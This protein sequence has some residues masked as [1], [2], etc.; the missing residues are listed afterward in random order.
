MI[1]SDVEFKRKCSF[2]MY[3]NL[4]LLLGEMTF[5]KDFVTDQR[6]D[7]YPV[8]GKTEDCR[9]AVEDGLYR[10]YTGAVR[11]WL[12]QFFPYATYEMTV[13]TGGRVGLCFTIPGARAAVL[14]EG[15]RL[16]FREGEREQAVPAPEC[17]E[18]CRTLA[19]SCRPGAFD[20]YFV[21]RG[22]ARYCCSFAAASFKES[23]RQAAFTNGNVAIYAR[24]DVT[25][26]A[27]SFYMDCGISQA[28]MRPIRYENGEIME[29]QGRVYLSMSVRMQEEMFQGIF[30]WEPGTAQF[31]LTGALFYDAGDGL[32]CGDVAATILYHREWKQWLLWVCSFSHG[33]I[34]GHAAFS[35]DPRFGVNVVDITLMDKAPAGAPL[36]VFAGVEG[37]EDPNFFYDAAAGKWH[38]A[39]CRLDPAQRGGYRYVFFESSQPFTGYTFV[40]AGK[41]GAETGGSFVNLQGE[42]LFVC[43]NDFRKRSDYRVYSKEGMESLHF[44][45]PDGGFRGWGTLIP[46]QR[47]S[48]T[49]CWMITFDRHNGSSYNWSYGN[50]YIF[51][52]Q[53]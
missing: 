34:L 8:Q 31:R 3:K 21:R 5:D 30:A 24:G 33:H 46:L 10:V 48:R 28:D 25:V 4:H 9:E 53:L 52:A 20:V 11:R 42:T 32:W 1:L 19:V 39:I 36:S 6:G 15:D 44:D 27:A 18:G 47:G 2:T 41:D 29:E 37:D 35:G 43:G 50:L 40:G 17:E 45:L 12:G 23:H 22:R 26:Y 7:L 13:G 51:E 49:R 16:I 38:M 14:L